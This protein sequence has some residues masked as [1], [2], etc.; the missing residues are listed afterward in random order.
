MKKLK[1]ALLSLL[2]AG[3]VSVSM[4]GMSSSMVHAAPIKDPNIKIEKNLGQEK[5]RVYIETNNKSAKSEITTQYSVRWNL[6]ENGFSTS[7]S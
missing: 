7:K 3:S 5:I 4:S 2:I 6:S 1:V